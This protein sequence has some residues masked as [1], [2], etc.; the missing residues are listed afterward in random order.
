[1]KNKVEIF[2]V[3]SDLR[4]LFNINDENNMAIHLSSGDKDSFMINKQYKERLEVIDILQEYFAN[5]VII[6]GYCEVHNIT[7]VFTTF[8]IKKGKP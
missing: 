5:K 8:E 1:M 7:F 2:T 4:K 6:D 3:V